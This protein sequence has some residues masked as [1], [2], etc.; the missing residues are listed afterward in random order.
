MLLEEV[1]ILYF[2]VYVLDWKRRALSVWD[3]EGKVEC[4][5]DCSFSCK[6]LLRDILLL[7]GYRLWSMA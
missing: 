7:R 3:L 1:S 6:L 2:D 5:V 4:G